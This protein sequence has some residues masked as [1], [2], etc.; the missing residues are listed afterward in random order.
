MNG[1]LLELFKL[2]EA[3]RAA[4]GRIDAALERLARGTYGVCVTCE[5][6]IEIERLEAVPEVDCC[7]R[8]A[9]RS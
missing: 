1:Q 6:P 3:E 5:A 2:D 7:G 9:S 4:I 8:C